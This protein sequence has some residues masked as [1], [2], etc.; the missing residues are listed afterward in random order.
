L[1]FFIGYLFLFEQRY[2]PRRGR[3]TAPTAAANVPPPVDRELQAAD[4]AVAPQDGE[5]SRRDRP[6]SRASVR[7]LR[8]VLRQCLRRA[9][10][11]GFAVPFE[12]TPAPGELAPTG[13]H[14]T[15]RERVD[16]ED[17]VRMHRPSLAVVGQL[18]LEHAGCPAD[19]LQVLASHDAEKPAQRPHRVGEVAPAA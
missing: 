12:V 3:V 15:P 11:D 6:R 18:R 8:D 14:D 2:G 16:V 13:A 10:L 5:H 17:Q 9:V 4:P 1:S 19:C 7:Q